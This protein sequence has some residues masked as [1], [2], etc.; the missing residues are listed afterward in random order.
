MSGRLFRDGVA[1]TCMAPKACPTVL[2]GCYY[3]HAYPFYNATSNRCVTVT[4]T[5]TGGADLTS[6]AYLG[7]FSPANIRLNHLADSGASTA[8]PPS[9]SYSFNV[10]ANALFTVVVNDVGTLGQYTL[11]VSGGDCPPIL[12]L[13]PAGPNVQVSWPTIA[14][15]YQL[16]ASRSLSPPVWTIVTNEPIAAG[17]HFCVSNSVAEMSNRFYRLH[18]PL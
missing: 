2:G 18:K 13:E 5:S 14:G 9:V 11:D 16:E 4:L 7:E 12:S 15:G 8:E 6:A 1:G 3:Y 10:P 17:N